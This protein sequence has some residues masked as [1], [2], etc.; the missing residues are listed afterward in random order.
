MKIVFVGY[1]ANGEKCLRA[2]CERGR[3]PALVVIPDGVDAGGMRAVAGRRE[4]PL[5]EVGDI[6]ALEPELRRMAPDLLVVAS[7]PRL[8]RA[9]LLAIP[10]KGELNVHTGALPRWRG[11]HPLNWALIHD[12]PEMGVTVHYMEE[13]ADSGGIVAQKTIP[14][15][16]EDDINS[17]RDKL[18]TLGA[19]LLAD[20]IDRIADGTVTVSP[21]DSAAATWAPRRRPEQGRLDWSR[22]SREV[23]SLCRA[24]YAPYPNAF[25]LRGDDIVR[26]E[27]VHVS[28]RP[29]TVLA[30]VGRCDYVVAT[31]DGT[32]FV[33]MDSPDLEPGT[34]LR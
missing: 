16:I 32:I 9:S 33:R 28:A 25:G 17:M 4:L 5:R 23:F 22:P 20:A 12:D 19:E 6:H 15:G 3:R 18:T 30:R 14:V 21:Q 7:Y 10:R 1:N 2:L 24:L 31:G 27:K 29:G 26:V 13:G 8:F 34:V 11:V